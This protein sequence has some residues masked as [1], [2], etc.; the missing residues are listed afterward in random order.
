MTQGCLDKCGRS[1]L[2]P[3]PLAAVLEPFLE[4]RLI[5]SS[6]IWLNSGPAF[7]C[8]RNL[9]NLGSADEC[10]AQM[11]HWQGLRHWQ[12]LDFARAESLAATS[13]VV[14]YRVN[15]ALPM[16]QTRVGY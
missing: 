2:C 10:N 13:C 11:C 1:S 9:K 7:A 5:A 8:S 15:R 16:S 4:K 14:L 6:E 12:D 3:R